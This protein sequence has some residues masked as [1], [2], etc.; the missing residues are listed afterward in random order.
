MLS[1]LKHKVEV[2]WNGAEAVAAV[3][4][5]QYDLILMDMQMPQMDGLDA[6]RMICS[7]WPEVRPHICGLTAN[8]T[9][10]DRHRC[11]DAG[12][13]YYLSKPVNLASLKNVLQ[14]V[15]HLRAQQGRLCLSAGN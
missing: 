13:D 11:M 12:M 7:R 6:T 15:G 2:A 3:A 10:H 8:A 1:L 4:V 14:T 5:K 9:P